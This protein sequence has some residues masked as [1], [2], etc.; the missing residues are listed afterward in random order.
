MKH[1]IAPKSGFSLLEIIIVLAIVGVLGVMITPLVLMFVHTERGAGTIDELKEIKQ[2]ILGNPEIVTREVRTDFGY[3]GDMGSLP[4]KIEDLYQKGVQPSF[5]FDTTKKTGAGWKGPYIDPSLVENL[6][7]LKLDAYGN[8][9]TYSTTPFTDATVGAT[10]SAK[11]VSKGTDGVTG[12]GDDL[13]A[14]V[15]K[16]EAFS[17]VRGTVVDELGNKVPSATVKIHYPSNGTLTT[18]TTTTDSTGQYQFTDIPY[19]NRSITIEPGLGY[20]INSAVVSGGPSSEVAFKITSF[21]ASDISITSFKADYT[22]TPTAFFKELV[23]GGTT[24]YNSTS[25]RLASG[26]TTTFSAI[27]IPGSGAVTAGKTFPVRVQSPLTHVEDLNI[28]S[29]ASKG[30]TITIEM[31]PFKDLLS[32]TANHVDMRGV[33]FEITFSDG[34]TTLFNTPS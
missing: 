8:E 32:G 5:A 27:I 18:A 21:S 11:I 28:G 1:T 16:R 20:A 15:Y 10:V 26:D 31:L 34:S 12:G 17:T 29:V 14:Y 2:G 23:I 7:S 4:T 22:V 6:A 3:I 9:Y 13:S 25:P 30:R 33:T 19:G 24:V